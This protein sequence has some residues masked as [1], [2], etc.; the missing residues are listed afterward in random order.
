MVHTG[1]LFELALPF[2]RPGEGVHLLLQ[3]QAIVIGLQ[4]ISDPAP[5]VREIISQPD[6]CAFEVDF[7]T[8]FRRMALALLNG[9]EM[10]NSNLEDK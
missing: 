7:G 9:I 2:L 6:L 4:H 3:L 8:E 10:V 5:V 1:E